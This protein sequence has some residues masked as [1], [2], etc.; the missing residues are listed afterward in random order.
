MKVISRAGKVLEQGVEET[1]KRN[2]TDILQ[3]PS[4]IIMEIGSQKAKN[5]VDEILLTKEVEEANKDGYIHITDREYY[6]TKSLN[7]LQYPLDK[8]LR[9]GFKADLCSLRPAK[10]IETAGVLTYILMEIVQNEMHGGQSIPAFDFYLAPY[11]RMTF[12]EELN[13]I[14]DFI[15]KELID[16]YNY[17]LEDYILKDTI[18]LEGDEK[19]IQE[20]INSTVRKVYQAMESFICNMNTI[21]SRIGNHAIFSTINYGTDTSAEGRCVI[22]QL[23]LVT[24]RGIGNNETP[25]FPVQIWKKKNGINAQPGDRNYD[26]F[27]CAC[28]VSAKRYYPNYINLDA[29]FN[30]NELW[31]EKNPNRYKYECSTMGCATRVFEN[32]FGE[33]TS[34]GRGNLSFSTINLP[35][36]AIESA[37]EAQEKTGTQFAIGKNS[38]EYITE[39]YKK[40]VTDIFM[41]KLQKYADVIAKQLYDRYCFQASAIK[42]QFPLLM[43]GLWKDSEN[44]DDMDK[45][46]SVLKHGTL[47]IGFIG[48][49]ECLTALIGQHHGE[50]EEAQELG[51]K[52]VSKLKELT[53]QYSDEYDLNY[54]VFGS[55]AERLSGRFVKNDKEK[56]GEIEGVTDKEY[57][58]N[59]NHVPVW[60]KCS[61]DRKAKIEGPYHKLMLGGHIFLVE[62]KRGVQNSAEAV[63][64]VVDLMDKYDI[65][66]CAVNFPRTKCAN[67]GFE[68]NKTDVKYCSVCDAED[69]EQI[70]RLAGYLVGTTDKWNSSNLAEL[71]DR[72]VHDEE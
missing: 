12:K 58:T 46:E 42:K 24:E 67:C 38:E 5:L 6:L 25:I 4:E 65:G 62:L 35:R 37:K 40:I 53:D 51:L 57:Y 56:F 41:D 66:Y 50:S 36:L 10:R 1:L 68:I 70:Q 28:L 49:A 60:F 47:E 23:L 13:K 39:E 14:G 2:S 63:E 45:V 7:N 30:Q 32:R 31:N 26:L 22:R 11:V 43:S 27:K 72:V 48:L 33:K 44:L 3:T 55:P 54:C 8:I 15:G 20:A 69:I 21:Y 16:L 9:Y 71:A 17:E 34:I 29:S 19:Y 59:S 18:G 52:I 64:D 61:Q